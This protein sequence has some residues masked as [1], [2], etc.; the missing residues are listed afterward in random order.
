MKNLL[1]NL[2]AFKKF[3][4]QYKIAAIALILTYIGIIHLMIVKEVDNVQLT[5]I[6][7]IVILVIVTCILDEKARKNRFKK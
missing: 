3:E 1:D 7:I 2:K 4:I 5:I 6:S